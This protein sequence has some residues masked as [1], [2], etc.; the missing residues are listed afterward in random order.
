MSKQ[1]KLYCDNDSNHWLYVQPS[2]VPRLSRGCGYNLV[3]TLSMDCI[4][5]LKLNEYVPQ[6]MEEELLEEVRV[7]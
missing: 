2:L 4:R 5:E 7:F 6:P 1:A 3:T